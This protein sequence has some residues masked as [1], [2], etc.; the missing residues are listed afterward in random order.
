MTQLLEQDIQTKEVLDWKGVH[1]FHFTASSCSQKTRIF[2]NLKG[3]EWE[4]H[5]INLPKGEQLTPWYLGINPRGLVPCLVLDGEVHIESNDIIQMLDARFPENK[6]IPDGFEAKMDK[7]LH[8]E[9]DLHL[10]L[11]SISF[12][13]T[14]AR[15]KAP[16]SAEDLQNFRERGSGTV[17]GKEDPNKAREIEY[18]ENYAKNE[19]VTDEA[20]KIATERFRTT[21]NELENNMGDQP[22][23]LGANLTVLDIAW[24][25]YVKRIVTCGYPLERLH[26]KINSWF[27]TLRQRP[28]FTKEVE[29]PAHIQEK[30][31][32]NHAAQA[33]AGTTLVK[34]AGL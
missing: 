17:R 26:P 2:L 16:K 33:A 11:R 14:H 12:R 3:I 27:L 21:L 8:H 13:Y 34:V 29:V 6:L 9:D 19:G 23:L 7:L 18:W 10:D 22:Y 30:I 32:A 20:I 31:D 25:V 4:S 28:E 1:L 15:G 24:Y 5:L